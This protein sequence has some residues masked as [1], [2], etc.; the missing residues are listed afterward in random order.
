MLE[1]AAYVEEPIRAT[2]ASLDVLQDKL[3]KSDNLVNSKYGGALKA[4]KEG[5]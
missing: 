5:R 2:I 3:R 1:N 4:V